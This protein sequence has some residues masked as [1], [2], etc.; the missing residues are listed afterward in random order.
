MKSFLPNL[1]VRETSKG[2]GVFSKVSIPKDTTVYEYTGD[3]MSLSELPFPLKPEDDHYLQIDKQ[4]YI[5]PSGDVDDLINHS[6]KPNCGVYVVGHRAFFF[7]LH[8]VNPG[9]E[10][11]FD[12]STTS[13]E[14]KDSWMLDCKC[15]QYGCR[16][17]ISGFQYLTEEQRKYYT[18]AKAVAGYLLKK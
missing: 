15:G 9:D 13:D 7:T 3:V 17:E 6:C 8:V 10:L 16:K 18:D 2:K 5:G 11:T 14:S 1:E 12:Y 4:K